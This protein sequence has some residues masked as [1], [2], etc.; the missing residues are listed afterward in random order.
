MHL[1]SVPSWVY[2]TIVYQIMP[3]R[4]ANGNKDNDPPGTYEW[5]ERPIRSSFCGGDLQG[6]IDHLDY[7]QDLGVETLYLTPIFAAPTTHKYD[8]SDYFTIDPA[9]GDLEVF[10]RLV[11]NCTIGICAL[12]STGSLITVAISIQR[13][14]ML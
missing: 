2:E 10:T 9:F 6:I 14:W 7:L 11:R 4:F 8:A 3:D 13:F 12:C 1:S 5:G